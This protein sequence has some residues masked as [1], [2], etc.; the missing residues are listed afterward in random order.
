MTAHFMPH[1]VSHGEHPIGLGAFFLVM[2][3]FGSL[4]LWVVSIAGGHT[5]AAITFGIITVA[6]FTT[7]AITMTIMGRKL[8]HS[9]VLPDNTPLNEQH[10]K[11][12]YRH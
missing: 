5:A 11:E 4:A 1:H 10:Y 3:G 7:S 9:P 12:M 2:V 6:A 8:H